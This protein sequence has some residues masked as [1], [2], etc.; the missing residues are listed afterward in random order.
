MSSKLL[1]KYF[2]NEE[3]NLGKTNNISATGIGPGT[4]PVLV[5]KWNEV[6]NSIHDGAVKLGAAAIGLEYLIFNNTGNRITVWT[7]S[8]SFAG[9]VAAHLTFHCRCVDTAGTKWMYYDSVNSF[10]Q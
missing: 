3:V 9:Y 4:A 6:N 1:D 5:N 2:T 8:G 10:N 7:S